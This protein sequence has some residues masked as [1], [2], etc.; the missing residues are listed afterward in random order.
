MAPNSPDVVG[1][2]PGF[3]DSGQYQVVFWGLFTFACAFL[4]MTVFIFLCSSC[5][6][7]SEKDDN[8]LNMPSEK[9]TNSY[10]VSFRSEL[11]AN[12][13]TE[14][15][16]NGDVLSDQS[17]IVNSSEDALLPV[18]PNQ[19]AQFKSAKCTQSRELPE[20]PG[21]DPT[22]AAE[23]TEVNEAKTSHGVCNTYEVLKDSS[24]QDIVIE[25]SLYETVKELKEETGSVVNEIY[26]E[27]E[28]PDLNIVVQDQN[29]QSADGTAAYA[30]VS[31]VKVNRSLSTEQI[32]VT[33]DEPPQ[34]PIKPLDENVEIAAVYST[35][36]KSSQQWCQTDLELESGYAC[37]EEVTPSRLSSTPNHLYASVSDYERSPKV[38]EQNKSADAGGEDLDPGYEAISG[39]KEAPP[40]QNTEAGGNQS[41]CQGENDY[42]SIREVSQK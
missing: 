32:L 31:K 29:Q 23:S 19:D 42:E 20:I 41:T 13:H 37:I 27:A 22:A 6:G 12:G 17:T 7:S 25:D 18:E 8:L 24:S 26:S 38:A 28:T 36:S 33:E 35:V 9:D 11:P 1:V 40:E 10:L 34:L 3:L 16:T 30:T 4:V 15:L 39:L 21:N 14:S 2:I 5:N